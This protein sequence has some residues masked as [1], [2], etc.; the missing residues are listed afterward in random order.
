MADDFIAAL[1][2]PWD[3]EGAVTLEREAVYRFHARIAK[4][5]RFGPV[6]LAGDAAPPDATVCRTGHVFGNARC[7]QP[8]VEARQK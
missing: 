4:E 2:K 7:G 1:L 3:V 5:W 8:V 6:L